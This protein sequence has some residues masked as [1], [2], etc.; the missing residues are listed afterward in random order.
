MSEAVH[1]NDR[2]VE[3]LA[4]A[5]T[6][7]RRKTNETSNS[8]RQQIQT[9]IPARPSTIRTNV[10]TSSTHTSSSPSVPI[11]SSRRIRHRR[12]CWCWCWCCQMR[13]STRLTKLSAVASTR[14]TSKLR[15]RLKQERS[16]RE[17]VPG[18]QIRPE[19]DAFIDLRDRRHRLSMT[20][21]WGFAVL[22]GCCRESGDRIALQ[23]TP[24]TERHLLD[25]RDPERDGE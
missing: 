4:T 19:P 14:S 8:H 10:S 6:N 9:Q 7:P 12:W 21:T 25:V 2:S 20:S 5:Q 16:L 23:T 11:S 1:A 18:L 3:R 17:V 22:L 15:G 24:S 13:P